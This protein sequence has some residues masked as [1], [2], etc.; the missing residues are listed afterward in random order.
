MKKLF[1]LVVISFLL[2]NGLHAQFT[3]YIVR[4]KNKGATSFSLANPSAYLS[5]RAIDRRTRYNIPVDSSDIPV[6]SSYITQIQNIP[7]VTLLNVS[8]G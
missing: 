7:N 3:R 8:S 1:A 4:L 5:Q 6:P 2:M